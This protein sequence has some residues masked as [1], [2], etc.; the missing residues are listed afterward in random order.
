MVEQEPDEDLYNEYKAEK[1]LKGTY[2]EWLQDQLELTCTM[3]AES[4]PRLHHVSGLFEG[5]NRICK[6]LERLG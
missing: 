5:G 4:T 1:D 3:L 6:E 2:A